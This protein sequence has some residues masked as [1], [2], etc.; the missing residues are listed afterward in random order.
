MTS[1]AGGVL[2]AELV[3]GA[4]LPEEN[5]GAVPVELGRVWE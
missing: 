2:F 3:P 5:A 4:A 1:R